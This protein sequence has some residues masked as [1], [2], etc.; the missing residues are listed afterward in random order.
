MMAQVTSSSIPRRERP[1]S[2][3]ILRSQPGKQPVLLRRRELTSMSSYGQAGG[4]LLLAALDL[5]GDGKWIWSS[6]KV[7]GPARPVPPPAIPSRWDPPELSC[8]RAM[9]PARLA[10]RRSFLEGPPRRMRGISSWQTSTWTVAGRGV[11]EHVR[12]PGKTSYGM[13][14][15]PDGS[16]ADPMLLVG[17]EWRRRPI[18]LRRL[19]WRGRNRPDLRGHRPLRETNL[20]AHSACPFGWGCVTTWRAIGTYC[21]FDGNGATRLSQS[22]SSKAS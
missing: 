9:G 11:Q 13:K 20:A 3:D 4:D 2:M 21:D 12:L 19:E 17:Y 16:L 15:N 5:N 6:S 10:C 8:T 1:V 14:R 22:P 18:I 7:G